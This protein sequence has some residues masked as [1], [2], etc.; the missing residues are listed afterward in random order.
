[1]TCI[2]CNTISL[3]YT[4]FTESDRREKFICE[5]LETSRGLAH[6]I[7]RT[8]IYEDMIHLYNDPRVICEH[9][10]RIKFEGEKGVDTG[11]LTR[12]AFSAF[13][14][15][16]YLRHFDGSS[17]LAPIVHAGLDISLTPHTWSY[18]FTWVSCLW[19]PTSSYCIPNTC[20]NPPW[21]WCNYYSWHPPRQIQEWSHTRRPECYC[22]C[23]QQQG[24]VNSGSDIKAC[25][26]F[27][28][29][30]LLADANSNQYFE[31]MWTYG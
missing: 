23:N 24:S 9:P 17:V 11:G 28:P 25:G 21:C 30:W 6:T 31:I 18:S 2:Y 19:V 16:A 12:D 1:M 27:Q 22:S 29:F 8:F 5:K 7:R 3:C 20:S 26:Y 14:E 13:W 4:Y 10:F 15:E